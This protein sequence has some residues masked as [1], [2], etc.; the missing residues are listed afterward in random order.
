MGGAFLLKRG[1]GFVCYLFYYQ[2]TAEEQWH[3]NVL[4]AVAG[5]ILLVAG[6]LVSPAPFVSEFGDNNA[7]NSSARRNATPDL[8]I[9][10]VFHR[11]AGFVAQERITT[12]QFRVST[13]DNV[14]GDSL[15]RGPKY[16]TKF[17]EQTTKMGATSFVRVEVPEIIMPMLVKLAPPT[18]MYCRRNLSREKSGKASRVA[19]AGRQAQA[20]T[21]RRSSGYARSAR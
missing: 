8:Q 3:V 15:T 11:Q 10:K 5:L 14:L 12:R 4:E 20:H 2:W 18:L 13:D 21:P 1:S 17:R 9:A 16:M 7:A 19:L 6:H